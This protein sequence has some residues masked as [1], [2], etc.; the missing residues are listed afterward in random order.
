MKKTLRKIAYGV[1][2]LALLMGA[3]WVRP[4]LFD[5]ELCFVPQKPVDLEVNAAHVERLRNAFVEIARGKAAP[6]VTP[7][8]EAC[9]RECLAHPESTWDVYCVVKFL[10]E[11][12]LKG[13]S[14]PE[15]FRDAGMLRAAMAKGWRNE[16]YTV[17]ESLARKDEHSTSARYRAR[18]QRS[19][20]TDEEVVAREI[21]FARNKTLEGVS[22]MP[23][24][25][26]NQLWKLVE[27]FESD[28][29]GSCDEFSRICRNPSWTN[30]FGDAVLTPPL[31][32]DRHTAEMIDELCAGSAGIVN[33]QAG[34][35]PGGTIPPKAEA[36]AAPVASE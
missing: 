6:M 17:I 21:V 13:G 26:Y 22:F 11:V 20:R 1:L 34:S 12:R 32:I 5:D 30:F 14:V 15:A 10:W 23:N 16:F 29:Y 3:L 25:T 4:K 28:P 2:G 8:L 33:G 24:R 9:V 7:E 36:K 27:R 18:G 31:R 19:M 35:P